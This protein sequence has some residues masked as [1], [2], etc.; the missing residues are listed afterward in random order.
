MSRV[1]SDLK[2][3]VVVVVVDVAAIVFIVKRSK[4]QFLSDLFGPVFFDG[5]KS[6]NANR[7]KNDLKERV[8]DHQVVE[9]QQ[10]LLFIR[11]LE[12]LAEAEF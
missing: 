10:R 2:L 9:P 6:A 1:F 8:Q 5:N 7:D 11:K 3:I 4:F 12:K